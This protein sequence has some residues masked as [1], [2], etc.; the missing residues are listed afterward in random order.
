MNI[1]PWLL[2]L[3]LALSGVAA[4][5]EPDVTQQRD[6]TIKGDSDRLLPEGS[7]IV[8]RRCLRCLAEFG[9]YPSLEPAFEWQIKLENDKY[10]LSSWRLVHPKSDVDFQQV[11]VQQL[12]VSKQF[13]ALV[14]DIWANNILEARF[15]RHQ[16][17]GPDGISYTFRT[18]LRG[19]GFPSA[20]T[21]EPRANLPPK[22]MVDAGE[23]IMTFARAKSAKEAPVL[24]KLQAARKR[25]NDYYHPPRDRPKIQP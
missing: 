22:W 6:E 13:A 12:E 15:T 2:V 5:Y 14:Y 3:S 8:E 18:N 24:A 16:P 10:V 20:S 21:R 7:G 1:R 9:R 23:E 4:A 11:D 19:V 17:S 25:L